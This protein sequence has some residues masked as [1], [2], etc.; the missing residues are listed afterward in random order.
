MFMCFTCSG[1]VVVDIMNEDA[2]DVVSRVT[3]SHGAYAAIDAVGGTSTGLL[4]TCV[5]DRGMA[6]HKAQGVLT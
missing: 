4:A 5:R 2:V 1:D 3:S 6:I